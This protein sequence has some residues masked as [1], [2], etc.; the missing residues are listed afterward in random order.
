MPNVLR[1]SSKLAKT[2]AAALAL[3]ILGA[4]V[5]TLSSTSPGATAAAV[6]RR[7]PSPPPG[8][9]AVLINRPADALRPGTVVRAAALG[10]RIFPNA[11]RGFALADVD[12]GQYPA[13]TIDGGTTW[14][15]DGPPLHVNAAQAPLVV[16]QV[17]AA[18]QHTFFAWGGPGGGQAVYVTS[19]AGKHW[20]RAILGDIV[21][22][23]VADSSG[24]LVAFA[25][26]VTT[27]DESTAATLVYVSKDGGQ[28]WHYSTR[29]GAI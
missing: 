26:A 4:L 12:D 1:V 15:V 11:R 7:D 22:A 6:A 17:G 3:A 18:N 13:T 24:R 23:V 2:V 20:Y 14:R 28:S 16:L 10:L 25:Q 19:D 5:I 29:L 21:M 27:S 9:T 8:V